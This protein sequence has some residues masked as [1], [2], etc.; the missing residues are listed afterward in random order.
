[1]D[2]QKLRNLIKEEKELEEELNYES[3]PLEGTSPDEIVNLIQSQELEDK[4]KYLTIKINTDITKQKKKAAKK[5]LSKNQR[6]LKQL[7]CMN[8]DY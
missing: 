6:R 8:A 4:V 5:K 7:S 2:L 3:Q 1:M